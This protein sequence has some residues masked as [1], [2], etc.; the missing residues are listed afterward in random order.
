MTAYLNG[1]AV[2]KTD[3]ILIEGREL[4]RKDIIELLKKCEEKKK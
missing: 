1:K 4:T 2:T 3:K